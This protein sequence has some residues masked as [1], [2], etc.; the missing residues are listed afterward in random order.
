MGAVEGS[1]RV[2]ELILP[3][4]GIWFEDG[5][6]KVEG[7]VSVAED[8][9]VSVLHQPYE[10]FGRDGVLACSGFLDSPDVELPSE[11]FLVAGSVFSLTVKM[12]IVSM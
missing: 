5:L 7:T 10:V 8:C 6:L 12:A 1:I 9:R 11:A 2:D 4:S 3:I